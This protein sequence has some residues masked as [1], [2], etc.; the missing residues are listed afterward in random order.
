MFNLKE[1]DFQIVLLYV[2]S[3]FLKSKYFSKSECEYSNFY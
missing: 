1:N 3:I 2:V